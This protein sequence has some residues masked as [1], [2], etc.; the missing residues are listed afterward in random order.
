[1]DRRTTRTLTTWTAIACSVVLS[2]LL[3]YKMTN[4]VEPWTFVV[5]VPQAPVRGDQQIHA[6]TITPPDEKDFVHGPSLIQTPAGLLAFWYRAVYEGAANA[7]IVSSRFD[8]T[9]WSPTAVVKDSS[10]VTRDI[11]LTVKSL[12]NPVAFRRSAN[13]IWLFFAASRLS[14]WATCEIILVRSTDNG[15]TWERAQRLYASPF[16]N[17]SHLTKSL[18]IRLSGDRI[19]LPAY[20]EM[21]R[22]YPI[23]LVLDGNGRV[24]DKVRMGN[25][26]TVGY[27][28]AIVPTSPTTAIAFVRRLNSFRPQSILIT[29]TTDAGRTWTPVAPIDLPNPGGPIAAIRYDETRI[30]LAFNDDPK[31]ESNVKLAFSNLDGTSF[32][33]IGTL[34]QVNDQ[35]KGDATAYPFLLESEPG[36][37]DVVFSR[38]PPQHVIDHVRVSSAW[39]EQNLE[40]SAEQK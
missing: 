27:Q 38:P 4:R 12:A 23:M 39:I 32:R 22:K 31:D 18:P 21:N 15:Q 26:G 16:L 36:Q 8:G 11:G 17:M 14:G 24:V 34:V 13:E 35:V 40:R 2:A 19:A 25:G 9:H 6:A 3:L 1:M 33:R 7:E 10:A 30:L 29:R 37:F 20:H 5:D 28:P